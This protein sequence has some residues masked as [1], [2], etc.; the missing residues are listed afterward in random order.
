MDKVCDKCQASV[1]RYLRLK[2]NKNVYTKILL[3]QQEDHEEC[4][5]AL[6]AAGADVNA[7]DYLSQ[8]ALVNA[9]RRG[10]VKWLQVLMTAGADVNKHYNL[11]ND[12]NTTDL[13]KM[14]CS[15]ALI[16]AVAGGN[17][18]CVKYLKTVIQG[19]TKAKTI[20]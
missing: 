8:T 10:H 17:I 12:R 13:D 3:N 19:I 5:K 9:A 11:L 15:N 4:V 6:L 18:Q 14:E 1:S 16:N 2:E 7:K 20:I